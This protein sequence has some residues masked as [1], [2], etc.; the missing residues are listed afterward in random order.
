MTWGA[1]NGDRIE[2][3]E[4]LDCLR[5]DLSGAAAERVERFLAG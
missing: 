3:V 4:R 2:R 1:P 5:P